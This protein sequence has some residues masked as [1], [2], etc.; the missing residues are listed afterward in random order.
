MKKANIKLSLNKK[1]ISNL[2]AHTIDGGAATN[3]YANV[4]CFRCDYTKPRMG[5]CYYKCN[6][7][8]PSE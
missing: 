3:P 5:S 4:T 7:A 8:N 6:P 2:E 1:K